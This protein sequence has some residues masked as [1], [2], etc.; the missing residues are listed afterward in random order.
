M[1][2][3]FVILQGYVRTRILLPSLLGRPLFSLHCSTC[4]V[5]EGVCIVFSKN[6]QEILMYWIL[7]SSCSILASRRQKKKLIIKQ[8]W[9]RT[10]SAVIRYIHYS[11]F[12]PIF[13]V[14]D[15]IVYH[16][17]YPQGLICHDDYGET[18]YVC[19]FICSIIEFFF[20][21]RWEG[22]GKKCRI[23]QGCR[24]R[25]AIAAVNDSKRKRKRK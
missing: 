24:I 5:S 8:N 13:H 11:Q 25:Q 15:L 2:L 3:F 10:K 9:K 7:I 14:Q 12:W 21:A 16:K 6:E 18:W 19:V 20:S 17:F 4:S 22:R 1:G 23:I